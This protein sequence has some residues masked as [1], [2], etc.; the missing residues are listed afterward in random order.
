MIINCLLLNFGSTKAD[1]GLDKKVGVI[2][3]DSKDNLLLDIQN[4]HLEQGTR[5]IILTF[6]YKSVCCYAEV[7]KKLKG[8]PE[9]IRQIIFDDGESSKYI[10][11]LVNKNDEIN[12][13]FG[14]I[15]SQGIFSSESN[16]LMVDFNKDGINDTFRSCTSHEGVHLS[17]WSG[18][19]LKSSRL[20]H[21]Y[22]YLGY[23]VEPSCVDEDF[24]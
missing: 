6:P 22:L 2:Y 17:I 4:S 11:K 14:I 9:T 1:T 21:A 12:F 18:L 5:I 23:D 8:E 15:D 24:K 20:W 10:L 7:V 13:G 19:P 3:L 16:K